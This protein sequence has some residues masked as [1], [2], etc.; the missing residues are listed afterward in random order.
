MKILAIIGVILIIDTVLNIILN[1]IN[2]KLERDN[3]RMA[4]EIVGTLKEKHKNVYD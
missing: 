4:N 3:E 2:R 1:I